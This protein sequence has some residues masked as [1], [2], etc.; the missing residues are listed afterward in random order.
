MKK[1]ILYLIVSL[2]FSLN[3]QK[4]AFYDDVQAFKKLDSLQKPATDILL[5]IG[6]SSFTRWKNIQQDLNN[7]KILNR[8]FG[9]STLLDLLRYQEDVIFKYQ[10][11][12]IFIYCGENDIASSENVSGKEVFERFKTLHQQ[13]RKKFPKVP[14][15]FISMKPSILRWKMRERLINGNQLIE[16][17][18]KKKRKTYFINIWDKMLNSEGLPKAD[19]F[20]ED[21]LHMNNKGYQI[22]IEALKKYIE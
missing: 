12:K 2:G 17:Y 13:I 1:V 4:P 21:N 20:V 11:Q 5:F 19:I 7:P 10:P 15:Y 6:S 8:A 16:Q 9:G 14:I 3:A 22:W 18:I